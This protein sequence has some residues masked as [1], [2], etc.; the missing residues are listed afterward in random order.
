MLASPV[1]LVDLLECEHRSYL[2]RTGRDDRPEELR[3]AASRTAAEMRAGLDLI[4]NAVFFE[5]DFHCSVQT[6]VRTP[7]GYEPCENVPEATPLAVLSLTA[8]AQAL[9]AEHAHLVVDG[10]RI[11]FRVADFT[12]L[13][14]RLKSRLAK[15]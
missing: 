1:D 15:P 4:E 6:L 9:N 8:A 14:G 3:E 5:R 2:A 13:L 7:D 12:P 10:K 11:S